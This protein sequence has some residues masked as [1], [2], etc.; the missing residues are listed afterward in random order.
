MRM[1]LLFAMS[2][3]GC[4]LI[5]LLLSRAQPQRGVGTPSTRPVTSGRYYALLIGVQHYQHPSVNP[6]DY[7]L[8]D[9]EMV[10][11]VLT[12]EYSF[13]RQ[14]VTLLKD[15]DRETI[16]TALSQL[17]EKLRAE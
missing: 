14:D 11:E 1:K 13:E 15:P 5:P 17:A 10:Q 16:L 2:L 3:I 12:A 9:A 7:P 6:L 8:N 4:L